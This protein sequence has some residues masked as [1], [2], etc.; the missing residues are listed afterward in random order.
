MYLSFTLWMPAGYHRATRILSQ[1]IPNSVLTMLYMAEMGGPPST[2]VLLSFATSLTYLGCA[3]SSI[4]ARCTC[5]PGTG[6]MR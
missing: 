1:D 2:L 6:L 5:L 4:V 3:R